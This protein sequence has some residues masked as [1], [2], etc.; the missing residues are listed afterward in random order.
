MGDAIHVQLLPQGEQGSA[1]FVVFL[2]QIKLAQAA[3]QTLVTDI[4]S[5]TFTD[6]SAELLVDQA[7]HHQNF[8]QERKILALNSV[9]QGDAGG[10]NE[11]GPEFPPTIRQKAEERCPRRQVGVRLADAGAGVA[12]GDGA[13]HH[14]VQHQ[15]TERDLFGPLSH[16]MKR[17]QVVKNAVDQIMGILPVII[18][19]HPIRSP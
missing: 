17:E 4:V 19:I 16:A 3:F 7:V 8:G 12:E 2:T 6:H 13:V 11:D 5:F 10:G 15:V 14:G 1:R 9:L 18:G